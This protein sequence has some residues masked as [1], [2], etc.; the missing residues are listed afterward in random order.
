MPAGGFL[1]GASLGRD[2]LFLCLSFFSGA[3]VNVTC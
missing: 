3:T 2:R 1:D